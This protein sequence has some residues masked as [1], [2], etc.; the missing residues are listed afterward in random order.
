MI[1]LNRKGKIIRNLLVIGICLFVM[2]WLLE[3]PAL[4]REGLF[5]RAG[6]QYLLETP[7][8]YLTSRLNNLTK[9][10]SFFLENEGRLMTV[11]YKKTFLG[12]QMG[13]VMLYDPEV[14]YVLDF[15][16][17][18]K[19]GDGYV[20]QFTGQVV[21]FLEEAAAAE[22]D[23]TVCME[24][25]GQVQRTPELKKEEPYCFTFASP[26]ET[27]IQ[28]VYLLRISPAVLRLYDE[29]GIILEETVYERLNIG[30]YTAEGRTV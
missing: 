21:G 18:R 9:V 22:L 3:F 15:D 19:E 28:A 12:Y 5:R 16:C 2:S 20:V 24:N 4:S 17:I 8:V 23:M 10:D 14:R 7:S 1:R 30:R 13:S 11:D 25:G 27:E 6:H 26:D 29:N